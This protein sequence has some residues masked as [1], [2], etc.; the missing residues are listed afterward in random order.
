MVRRLDDCGEEE[1]EG[2]CRIGKGAHVK[3]DGVGCTEFDFGTFRV[4]I[5]DA[6]SDER[7]HRFEIVR[8]TNGADVFF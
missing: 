3:E 1:S 6:L 7:R 8:I 2:C 5:A 4:M